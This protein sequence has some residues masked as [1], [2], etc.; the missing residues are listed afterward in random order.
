[1]TPAKPSPVAPGPGV[2]SATVSVSRS[3]VDLAGAWGK[4][5]HDKLLETVHV[6]S[7]Q[8]PSGYYRLRR[9]I[10]LPRLPAYQR[11]ILRFEAITYHGRVFVNGTELGTMGPYVPYEFDLS[12]QAREGSNVLEVAI[13]DL[14]A[15]PGGAGKDELALGLNPGWEGYGGII[16][17]VYVELRPSAFVDNVQLAY[18]LGPGYADAACRARVWVS[19]SS[20]TTGQLAVA[21]LQG[22]TE[23]AR[24]EKKIN[25]PAGSSDTQLAF[26]LKSPVLWS[27]EAPNLYTLRAKIG[28]ASCR[29]RV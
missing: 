13:A 2:P 7:S 1:M 3:R 17:D 9:E 19:S 6:P 21:L 15:E 27:P 5:V 16:R 28:R 20:P 12:G 24:A 29:E 18:A 25:V 11:A 10:V 23:V 4:Y 14:T 22:S 8:R 26:D